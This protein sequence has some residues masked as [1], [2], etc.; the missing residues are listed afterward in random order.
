[1][2]A[3]PQQQCPT[4]A[5]VKAAAV[6]SQSKERRDY[7]GASQLGNPCARAIWYEYHGYEREPFD[8]ET[9]FNF[10][11]GHRTEELVIKRFKA[12]P[13][14]QIWDVDAAGKQWGFSAFGGKLKG[15]LDGVILGLVQAPKTPHVF[16]VK[17]CNAK[18]YA[19]LAKAVADYGEKQALEK[20]NATYFAQAQLYCHFMLLD[21]HY[22]VAAMAGGRDMM[23]IRTEYQP[24]VAER[25]VDKAEKILQATSE[26][27]RVSDKPDFYLCRWCAFAKVCHGA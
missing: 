7:L 13:F 19:E 15:H 22:L 4:I 2:V 20:W 27:A 21:R 24:E 25:L 14:I 5:A 6:A 16:E 9:L 8:A 3:I 11:D 12:L 23:A 26:P 10:E 18:K 17:A 1:M